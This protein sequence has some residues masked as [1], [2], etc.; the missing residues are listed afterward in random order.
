MFNAASSYN[1]MYICMQAVNVYTLGAK[2]V[3]NQP[4][5]LKRGHE[6]QIKTTKAGNTK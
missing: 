4:S 6:T 1:A 2:Y 3:D 5:M